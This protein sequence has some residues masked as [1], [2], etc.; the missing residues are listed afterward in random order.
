MYPNNPM[1]NQQMALL[2]QEYSQKKANLMQNFY[3][4]AQQNSWGQQNVSTQAAAPTP[5]QNVNW[6]QVSGVDGAKNQIVQPGQTAWMMDNNQPYFYVKS[7]DNVGSSDF[8]IFQFAEV[9]DAAQEQAAQPQIDTSQYVQRAE[10]DELKAQLEQFTT[11]KKQPNKANK[12][13]EDNG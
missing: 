1:L 3:N 5:S 2:D 6:I 13:V 12:G 4:Q 10:F 9:A 8:R 11:Q 7:V